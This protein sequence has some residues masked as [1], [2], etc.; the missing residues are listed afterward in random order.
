ML[1]IAGPPGSGKTTAASILARRH[2]LR[3]YS[4]DTRT[5]VHRDRAV[6]AGNAAAL[7]WEALAPDL[8]R[9]Q[10][11]DELLAMSLHGER[12]QMVVADIRALPVAPLIVAEGSVIRPV[13]LPVGSMAVW[14]MPPPGLQPERL[15]A[16]EGHSV[17]LYE[18]LA[19][20]IAA[21]VAHAG[22]R[23]IVAR[24]PAE[25]VA[26]L[27]TVFADTL[28]RGPL[29]KSIAER[30]A[31]LRESNLDIV[32]QVRG[33]YARPWAVGNPEAVVRTFICECGATTCEAFVETTVAH[34]AAEPA[35]DA[36][37]ASDP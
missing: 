30:R 17:P 36:R 18:L 19:E 6:A 13:D 10:P 1:W 11:P 31:L 8:R 5:W 35:L 26:A 20:V 25:T 29:A 22:A 34:A 7:R 14:L 16:R 33:Y 9:T 24:E 12:G 21:E 3:L 28:A 4:A 27:E 23:V 37:H 15:R 2:G 32:E